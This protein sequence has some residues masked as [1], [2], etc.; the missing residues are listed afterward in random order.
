MYPLESLPRPVLARSFSPVARSGSWARH[1][2]AEVRRP[3][4]RRFLARFFEHPRP[5]R[6]AE[7][8]PEQGRRL[9]LPASA[10]PR[11]ISPSQPPS[12][13]S[14]PPPALLAICPTVA[15]WST[16]RVLDAV[17]GHER[18]QVRAPWAHTSSKPSITLPART[19]RSW[20]ADKTPEP[21]SKPAR[22]RRRAARLLARDGGKPA[23]RIPSRKTCRGSTCRTSWRSWKDFGSGAHRGYRGWPEAG[24]S[25]PRKRAGRSFCRSATPRSPRSCWATCGPLRHACSCHSLRYLADTGRD[26]MGSA[27]LWREPFVR[28]VAYDIAGGNH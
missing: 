23:P 13:G 22:F 25:R 3:G 20:L 8:Q 28:T 11:Q 14:F 9:F 16:P 7:R 24:R 2:S 19:T 17:A 1:C 26:A 21:P 27:G 12:I 5:L 6:P 15:Q 18:D 4:A 10:L